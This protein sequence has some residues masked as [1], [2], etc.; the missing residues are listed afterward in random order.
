M[1]SHNKVGWLFDKNKETTT[2]NFIYNNACIFVSYQELRQQ[3]IYYY[4]Y[5]VETYG[6][7]HNKYNQGTFIPMHISELEAMNIG[8]KI[9][10]FDE[11]LN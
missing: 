6:I 4:D 2:V 1:K 9:V 10:N 7:K 5:L 8:Y 11:Y 3:V